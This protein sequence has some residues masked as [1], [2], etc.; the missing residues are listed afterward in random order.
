MKGLS[1]KEIEIVSWLEF[2]ERYFFTSSDVERFVRSRMQ[3]YSII[4]NLARKGR[5][6][7]LNRAKYYLV[8]IKAKSGKWSENPFIIADEMCNS[9]DYFIGGWAA[10]N[11]W[12]LTDQVPMRIDVYTTRRQG[13][14]KILSA[15]II[16]HRTSKKNLEKAVGKLLQGHTFRV[17][18]KNEAKKWLKLRQ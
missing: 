14:A 2:H 11:Y 10:A 16:F 4:K 7:K 15:K 3:R 13:E 1:K 8:P 18:S 12:R 5:I 17:A 6:I 9:R